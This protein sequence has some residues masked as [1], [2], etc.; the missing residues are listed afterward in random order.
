MRRKRSRIALLGILTLAFTV[1][2]GL[3]IS[4]VASAQKKKKGGGGGSKTLS[5]PVGPIPDSTQPI[6]TDGDG[7]PNFTRN[8]GEFHAGVLDV[9]RTAGRKLAGA[10]IKDLNVQ[11]AFTH[12]DLIDVTV[13]LIGPN[14]QWVNLTAG[15][16]N[17]PAGTFPGAGPFPGTFGPTTFDDQAAVYI[18]DTNSCPNDPDLVFFGTTCADPP[19]TPDGGGIE[20][21][22]PYL[23][24]F[25]P[26]DGTLASLGSK[27]QGTWVLLA[28]DGDPFGD[29]PGDTIDTGTVTTAKLVAQLKGGGGKKKK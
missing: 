1:T 4:D 19:P 26:Q 28:F 22:P 3:T 21:R 17:F 10:K 6:D 23:G 9:K 20:A 5:F 16:A 15:N 2:A 18:N 13:N 12:G 29:G 27:L 14:G 8:G 11:L 7:M 24:N 25:K